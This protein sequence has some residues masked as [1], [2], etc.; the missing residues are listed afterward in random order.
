MIALERPA[1]K[2]NE[3][4]PN[5]GIDVLVVVIVVGLL[6]VILGISVIICMA[7]PSCYAFKPGYYRGWQD[8]AE[9]EYV[10]LRKTEQSADLVLLLKSLDNID[11]IGG[12][13]SSLRSCTRETLHNALQ[14]ETHK[15]VAVVWIEVRSEGKSGVDN[16]ALNDFYHFLNGLGYKRILFLRDRFRRDSEACVLFDSAEP[17]LQL[18]DGYC[19]GAPGKTLNESEAFDYESAFRASE[20]IV[21]C[22]YQEYS[23]RKNIDYEHPPVARYHIVEFLKGP[24]MG[25]DPLI[26]HEFRNSPMEKAPD[27]WKFGIEK[28]PKKNSRWLIFV[29]V[30]VP[31]NGAFKTYHGRIGRLPSTEETRRQLNAV[32]EKH[33]HN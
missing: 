6:K 8:G 29:P 4:A 27:G 18:V 23:K 10:E 7:A 19:L 15:Q 26:L 25:R 32:I 17:D 20:W 21:E 33:R 9:P 11:V 24:P 1:R 28:M 5:N 31:D 3:W 16:L 22:E 14:D 13:V 12:P 30:C 2:N